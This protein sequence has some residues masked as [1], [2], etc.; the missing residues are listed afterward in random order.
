MIFFDA[1]LLWLRGAR[2]RVFIRRAVWGICG[3]DVEPYKA[4]LISV[5]RSSV[6]RAVYCVIQAHQSGNGMAAMRGVIF[7][8]WAGV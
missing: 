3:G 2:G 4:G 7:Y 5:L 8:L 6:G 1:S